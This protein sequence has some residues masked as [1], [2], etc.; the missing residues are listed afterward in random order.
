MDEREIKMSVRKLVEFILRSGD[1]DSRFVGSSRAV[2]GTRIHKKVQK[3]MG[4]E[5]KAEVRLKHIFEYKGFTF[6][7]EGRADGIIDDDN[8]VIIDEIKS[9]TR[10]L[11]II[12]EEYNH[13]HWAQAKCY[14]Y[15]YALQNDIDEIDIQLTYYHVQTEDIK[16]LVQTYSKEG[17]KDFFYNLIDKYLVWA[18]YTEKWRKTRNISIKDM[19][20]PFDKYRDGQRKLA[21]AVYRTISEEKRLFTQAPTGIG[22]T[23]STIFPTIKA[24]GEGHSDK[25]FYLTAKTITRQV[26]EETFNKLSKKGLRFKSLTLTAKDKICFKEETICNPDE[27]E[28]AKGHFDR[29]NDAILDILTNEDLTTRPLIEKYAQKHQVCPFEFSLDLA[30]W[31]DCVICDYNYAFDPRVYLKR[32]FLDN[33]GNYT[34]LVDEAHNLVDRSREMFSA[35][36]YKKPILELKRIMKEENKDI[37]NALNKLNEYMI[38]MRKLCDEEN[39]H[40]KDGEPSKLYPLLSKLIDESEEWLTKNQNK[41]GYKELL[42]LYFNAHSFNNIAENYDESYVTYIEEYRNNDVKLKLFCLDPAYLLSEA[43]KRGKSAI[44]FSATLTPLDYFRDILGGNEEDYIMKLESPFDRKNLG[45]LVANNIS[46]KYRNRE[47]SYNIISQYINVVNMQKQGN[48]LVFF[49]SYKYMNE[50]YEVFTESYPEANSIIQQP[51]MAEN[52][53]EIF[54][55]NFKADTD[56]NVVG[57]AVLG[58]VFSEGVDLKGERLIGTIIVG[59]GLPQICFERDLIKNY[60]Q[61]KNKHGYEY[62]YIYPGMN[63][64]LQAAG[65]V[66]RSEDDKG[67]VILI[68]ERFGYSNY[69][70][71]FPKHWQENVRIKSLNELDNY[72]G[73]FWEEN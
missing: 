4:D 48:Y 73:R 67:I 7:I 12:D 45:L 22:K 13:L 66:I 46:T 56:G 65:R 9:T 64:V 63:K 14:G 23:I 20:F 40:E 62:A 19:K 37:Y 5:Y 57:F 61:D 34:F 1:L 17:L 50:V 3:S 11:K 35:E 29:I 69:Q 10:P 60:F 25:I 68:D 52:E 54:L 43:I 27:C 16:R 18:E 59:V 32:F 24:I 55:D 36:I 70:K 15:I 44:F 21:V 47:S 71:L 28:F 33:S 72:V 8:G 6:K 51:N 58:G 2:E 42:E 53:R 39:F 49:P 30:L 26:A 31:S 41:N 38:K